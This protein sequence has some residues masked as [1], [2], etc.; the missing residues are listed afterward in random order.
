MNEVTFVI[1]AYS[2]PARL[3]MVISSIHKF[4]N[5][6][7][8]LVYVDKTKVDSPSGE[9]TAQSQVI[10]QCEDSLNSGLIESYRVSES[11]QGT[12]ASYFACFTWGF[13]SSEHVVLLEDD[14]IFIDNPASF[15]EASIKAFESDKSVGMAVL[16][17][18]FN[19][20]VSEDSMQITN[21][22]IMWGVLLNSR[23]YSFISN[24]LVISGAEDVSEV[25]S[26]FASQKIKS[27]LQAIFKDRF[28]GTWR[29]KYSRA[30]ESRTAWD[31]QWQFALW[32][33]Q[34]TTAVP[35]RTLIADLGVDDSSVSRIRDKMEPVN[36]R[37]LFRH[38][39][40]SK[41]FCH[42]CESFREVQNFSLPRLLRGN[43]LLNA[44]IVR[45][46]L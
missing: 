15:I 22:P 9:I 20:P 12:K 31:T 14:M 36:C 43:G 35:A 3:Q 6:P 2:R 28:E 45:G 30:L 5:N 17:A 18:N 38:S 8:I 41:H 24:Y 27:R 39:V 29:F 19:H 1:L 26:Q 32:G 10:A 25:V 33:L 11:N 46:I 34:L 7:K 4:V 16:F 13:L 40:E 23:N 37:S 21:W 42:A 44:L